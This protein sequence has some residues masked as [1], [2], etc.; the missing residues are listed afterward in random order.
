MTLFRFILK[1][2]Y[3]ISMTLFRFILKE[4]YYI[5]M[6]LFRFT[7]VGKLYIHDTFYTNQNITIQVDKIIQLLYLFAEGDVP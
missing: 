5:S 4:V 2:V 1:E 7:Q 6:T 3:Y